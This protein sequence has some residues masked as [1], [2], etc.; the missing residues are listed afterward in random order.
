M[1]DNDIIKA[2]EL[3]FT[4]K[5]TDVTCGECPYHKHGEL[6]KVKRDKDA[7]DLL[8]R[9]KTDIEELIAE[10]A[11]LKFALKINALLLK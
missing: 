10:N 8:N 6:C 4:P 3:C 7:L 2:L 9:Q 5:G 11:K 1:N